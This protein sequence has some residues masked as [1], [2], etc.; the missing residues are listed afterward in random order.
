MYVMGWE[1]QSWEGVTLDVGGGWGPTVTTGE[2]WGRA[3]ILTRGKD[4]RGTQFTWSRGWKPAVGVGE[5]EGWKLQLP[6]V[7][8]RSHSYHGY[9]WM[10]AFGLGEG[11]WETVVRMKG[12]RW[13][14][15]LVYG[16]G[17]EI[18]T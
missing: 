6:W 4:S 13:G 14:P 5:E 15:H 9:D 2:R 12:G 8:V 18:R 1:S 7:R 3:Q 11:M 17:M 10:P 16:D